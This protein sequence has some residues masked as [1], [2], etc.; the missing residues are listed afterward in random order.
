MERYIDCN[1]SV[2]AGFTSFFS[3]VLLIPEK[4]NLSLNCSKI[5]GLLNDELTQVNVKPKRKTKF[6]FRRAL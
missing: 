6:D 5:F 4:W 2:N 1:I 3:N